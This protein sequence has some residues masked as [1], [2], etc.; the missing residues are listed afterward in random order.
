M[1]WASRLRRLACSPAITSA[2]GKPLARDVGEHEARAAR[3]QIE[4]VVVVASHRAGL[5]AAGRALERAQ[6]RGLLGQQ[7][8]LDL[9]R[10]L[11]LVGGAPLHLDTVRH[12]LGEPDVVEGD[13][14]LAPDR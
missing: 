2:A 11:D 9:P 5:H 3:T 1:S 4:K 6:R 13:G 14:G 12:L 8:A 10:Q 7:L